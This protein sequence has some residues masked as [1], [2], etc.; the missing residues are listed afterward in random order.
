MPFSFSEI[1]ITGILFFLFTPNLLFNFDGKLNKYLVVIIHALLF[2]LIVYLM[3]TNQTIEGAS[4]IKATSSRNASGKN[5]GSMS[6]LATFGIITAVFAGIILCLFI[7]GY[8]VEKYNMYKLEPYV[9]AAPISSPKTLPSTIVPVKTSPIAT[10]SPSPV[11]STPSPI[12]TSPSPVKTSP[13]SP[14]KNV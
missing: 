3:L 10:P 5:A 12:A 1:I 4:T 7:Y 2:G 14:I 9:K 11:K 6:G 8:I 13:K